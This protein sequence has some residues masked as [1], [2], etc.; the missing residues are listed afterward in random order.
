MRTGCS[1]HRERGVGG[2]ASPHAAGQK[3][4]S[5]GTT[6]IAHP[7]RPFSPTGPT[8]HAMPGTCVAAAKPAKRAAAHNRRH[9]KPRPFRVRA[10]H[11]RQPTSTVRHD[12]PR[13]ELTTASTT[14]IT[15]SKAAV[16][17]MHQPRGRA[18]LLALLTLGALFFVC[19]GA[20]PGAPR[21][22][23]PVSPHNAAP[24]PPPT[25]AHVRD[26]C[27]AAD[28]RSG[29]AS[30]RWVRPGCCRPRPAP[31]MRRAPTHTRTRTHLR[32]SGRLPNYP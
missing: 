9:K 5:A 31:I 13:R 30:T 26:P 4:W 12:A 27:H 32:G 8:G 1:Y 7:R 15:W 3:A 18:A 10:A 29:A 19:S 16:I 22:F 14:C 2:G 20:R 6:H 17:T 23:R 21:P 25:S 28:L 11:N 24:H